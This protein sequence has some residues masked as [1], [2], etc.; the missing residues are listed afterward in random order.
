M[1]Q[2]QFVIFPAKQFISDTGAQFGMIDP[3]I[4]VNIIFPEVPNIMDEDAK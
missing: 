1:I 4:A 2:T 3:L